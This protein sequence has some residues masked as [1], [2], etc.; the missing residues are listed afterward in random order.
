M[1]FSTY[2]FLALLATFSRESYFFPR[3]NPVGSSTTVFPQPS[4][5][6]SQTLYLTVTNLQESE[7]SLLMTI[8]GL[9]LGVLSMVPSTSSMLTIPRRKPLGQIN[10]LIHSVPYWSLCL[11]SYMTLRLYTH[12]SALSEARPHTQELI[13]TQSAPLSP[14]HVITKA[15]FFFSPTFLPNLSAS[16]SL[17]HP[18]ICPRSLMGSS[19]LPWCFLMLSILQPNKHVNNEFKV[20]QE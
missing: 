17:Y 4:L 3:S 18:L 2:I 15:C 20:F 5:N 11:T 8:K 10:Q 6:L 16:L 14:V 7:A 9:F 12:N 1:E 19:H 13:M